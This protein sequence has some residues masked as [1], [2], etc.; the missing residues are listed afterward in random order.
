MKK[1]VK[2]TNG[3]F[4]KIFNGIK[5]FFTWPSKLFKKKKKEEVEVLELDEDKEKDKKTKVTKAEKKK[6]EKKAKVPKKVVI[7]KKDLKE[8]NRILNLKINIL[9]VAVLVLLVLSVSSIFA[10]SKTTIN[11]K[12]SLMEFIDAEGIRYISVGEGF[13][14]DVLVVET[15]SPL[16]DISDYFE[17]SYTVSKNAT[18]N[19]YDGNREVDVEDF[20]FDQ[21]N[22][23]HVKGIRRLEVVIKTG[24]RNKEEMTTNLAIVDSEHPSFEFHDFTMTLGEEFDKRGFVKSYKDNRGILTEEQIKKDTLAE[25]IFFNENRTDYTET[26]ING[27]KLNIAVEV[28]K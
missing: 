23:K 15:S 13:I 20:T 21:N 26:S 6:K 11:E 2:S 9:T 27:E 10:V 8:E 25:N 1:E 18:I 3:F 28:I 16:P 14:K 19:Y 22:E 4:K 7:K 24:D 17:R 12:K 5:D